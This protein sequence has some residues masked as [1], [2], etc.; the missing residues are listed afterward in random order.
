M[1]T[2][3]IHGVQKEQFVMVLLL[4]VTDRY[5][6]CPQ[7]CVKSVNSY[8]LI[9]AIAITISVQNIGV[10]PSGPRLIIHDPVYFSMNH[11]VI[12]ILAGNI[13]V[14]SLHS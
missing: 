9:I 2:G 14:Y 3:A 8:G 1:L 12:Q 13:C 5:S 4:F 11:A 7:S 10:Q 6:L